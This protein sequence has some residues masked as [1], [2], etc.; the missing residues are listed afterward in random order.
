LRTPAAEQLGNPG[1]EIVIPDLGR[2]LT[3]GLKC[4]LVNV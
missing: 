2:Y 3:K 1:S 4:L